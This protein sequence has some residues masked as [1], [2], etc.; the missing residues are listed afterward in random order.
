[1]PARGLLV[2]AAPVV[3]V[4]AALLRAGGAASAPVDPCERPRIGFMGPVTGEAAFIG[5]EQLGF[6]RYA[7]TSLGDGRI[8][9][10]EGDTQLEPARAARVAASLH[11][12]PD[13]LAVVGP[14]G[15]R[16]VLAVAPV[17]ARP[18]RMAFVSGSA[19]ETALTNGSIPS[20]F[21]VVP[22]DRVQAGTIA[23]LIRRRL[24]ARSVAIVEDG[25]AYS[26]RLADRV[27][28][29]LR[30]GGVSVVR[31]HIDAEQTDFRQAVRRLRSTT[32]VVF[33]PFHVAATAQLFGEQ[34]RRQGSPATVVG[35]DTL[36]S[37][38]FTLSGA[39]VATFAPRVRVPGYEGRAATRFGPP[40]FVATE[41]AVRAIR[42]ACADGR[43]TRREVL[44]RIRATDL[45]T[46]LGRLRF[47]SRGDVRGAAY[48]VFRL[49]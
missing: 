5:K 30:A 43:A 33:L 21:R 17:F 19:L 28:A 23:R 34:L 36:D 2:V 20:F 47:T 1:M 35:S 24:G 14:A 6:A 8:R 26:R 12:T 42:A 46:V 40:A 13:V 11:R 44:E 4:A 15:S 49:P 38:D 18:E 41:V 39:Y 27:Q 3:L 9:L 31:S 37:R 45:S 16:E 22:S 29:S 25:T 48:A 10:L 7:I 32:E